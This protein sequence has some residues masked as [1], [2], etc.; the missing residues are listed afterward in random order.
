MPAV[1][2]HGV[3][4]SADLWDDLRSHLGR[5]DH[6]AI[7]LPGFRAP[8]PDGF[9]A[10]MDSYASWL[11]AGLESLAGSQGPIDLVG[12]D[13]G[14][15]LSLRVASTRP[16]LLRSWVSD[17]G[18]LFDPGSSWHTVATIW[19]MPEAGEQLMAGMEAT[20][21]ADRIDST[22]ALG[23]PRERAERCVLGDPVMDD[24][25][26]RLYRSATDVMHAWGPDA[27]RAA[28]RPGLMIVPSD[29]PFLDP[30]AA[31]RTAA[32][33]SAQVAALD[34]LGHWWALQDPERGARTIESFW[35][36][37]SS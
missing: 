18:S 34:G 15:L 35:Q 6:I 2:V 22:A 10:T 9:D 37:L 33:T 32:R 11:T 17:A 16:D 23:V 36:S 7:T 24:C 29:D 26:L 20:A 4:E 8:V 3:P 1:F 21:L 31:R 28:E 30:E 14:G 13:W 25:I 12:H 19:Q 27:E 5:D